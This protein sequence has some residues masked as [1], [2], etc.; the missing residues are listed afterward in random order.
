MASHKAC[1]ESAMPHFAN[2]FFM[3]S[4]C[5]VNATQK[6]RNSWIAIPLELCYEKACFAVLR[7]W[8]NSN[9]YTYVVI[10]LHTCSQVKK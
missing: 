5:S 10:Y 4:C 6:P 3:M 9:R 2:M 1:S 8:S 7:G